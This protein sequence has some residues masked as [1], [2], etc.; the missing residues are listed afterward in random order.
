MA[1]LNWGLGH[2]TR[3]IPLIR[4]LLTQQAEVLIASDGRAFRLLQKEFPQLRSF[5][6]PAYDIT[7]PSNSMLWNMAL[8]LPK[9]QR[10]IRAEHKTIRQLVEQEKI[11]CIISDNRY[12][13][14]DQRIISIFITHQVF[15]KSGYCCGDYLL[16]K[17]NHFLIQRF[18]ELWI[19]DISQFPGL[20]GELSHGEISMAHQYLGPLSR[21]ITQEVP[22]TYDVAVVLS[23][24]EPQRSYLEKAI[25]QQAQKSSRQFLI[26]QGVT[27]RE[28]YEKAANIETISYL[29]GDRL[30]QV[31]LGS[32][33]IISRSG[34]STIMD[35]IKIQKPAILVPTPGQ[36]EQEYLASLF[37]KEGIFHVQ[38]QSH[39]NLSLALNAL[40]NYTYS[41]EGMQSDKLLKTA[42]RKLLRQC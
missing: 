13:C 7:Y 40:D 35:L 16:K 38:R 21:F 34:Y 25:R 30:N 22:Q 17:I 11:D 41:F 10:A 23:G 33:A 39:L 8:Q 1:P 12:G 2:A 9:I 24:P 37:E 31:L 6:L 32:K 15:I 4:E 18:D 42:V 3:C 26:I 36:T 19:P 14:Y 27:D 28:K 5:L 29:K 20:A